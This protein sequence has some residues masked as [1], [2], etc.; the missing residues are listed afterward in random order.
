MS[1]P[2]LHAAPAAHDCGSEPCGARGW[3]NRGDM[4]RAL[5]R[6]REAAEAYRR[7]VE[8]APRYVAGHCALGAVLLDLGR[9]NEAIGAF[10][11]ARLL[12]PGDAMIE[13][14]LLRALGR[15]AELRDG[16]V[17]S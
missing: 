11:A 8:L 16:V 1:T 10:R 14:Q 7:L 5:G 4:L 6:A 12:R 15:A 17:Y 2:S 9:I 3:L 13:F